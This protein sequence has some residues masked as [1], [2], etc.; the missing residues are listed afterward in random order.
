MSNTTDTQTGKPETIEVD[1]YGQKVALPKDQGEA[2]IKARDA[3]KARRRELDEKTGKLEAEKSAAEQAR[4]KA[5]E[6]KS[7]L[8]AMKAGEVEKAKEILT[9]QAR[10]R[11]TRLS[12]KYLTKHLTAALAQRQDL[13]AT[14]VDDIVDRLTRSTKY[15]LDSDSIVVLDEVGQ[16]LKDESGKPVQVDSWLG[17][18]LEK[19]PHYLRDKTPAGSGAAGGKPANGKSITKAQ[20]EQMQPRE[21]AVFFQQGGAI[22]G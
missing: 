10:E 21:A 15:D 13:V 12:Q 18:W 6:E 16:P 4:A 20:F 17:K 1:L 19:R 8:A 22:A 3:D 7:A 14:A 9:A 5:E 11:E 2:L